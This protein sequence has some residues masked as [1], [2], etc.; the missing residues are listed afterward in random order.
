M[1]TMAPNSSDPQKAELVLAQL[2]TLPPLAP[3]AARILALTDDSKSNAKQIVELVGADPALAARML[4]ILG[5]AEH[6]LRSQSISIENAVKMLGFSA[7]RQ[8]TL[9]LKVMETFGPSRD[10]DSAGGGF[11]RS[12][13][14]K[15]CLAVACAARGIASK[16][17]RFGSPDEA[18]VHGLLHDIGK[19]A[20]ETAM[21]KTFDRI[22]Q[23]ADRQRADIADIEREMIGVDHAVVGHRLAER[24]NLPA[25]L[26]ECIWLHHQ[27]PEGL[28]ASIAA[29]GHVQIVQLADAM[30]RE[31]RIGYSGNHRNVVGSRTL[32][33]RIGLSEAARQEIAASL[34]EEIEKRAAW[35]GAEALNSRE[36]Y[37][38]ALMQTTEE[39]TSANAEL[40]DRSL[41]LQREREYFSALQRL[42]R[43]ITPRA[44]V[45]EVCGIAASV[46]QD[47]L[48]THQIHV[49]V[50]TADGRW[51]EWGS[52]DAIVRTGIEECPA[53]AR[54]DSIDTVA[55]V[56]MTR[57]AFGWA[58]PV[59]S[60]AKWAERLRGMLGSGPLWLFPIVRE[61]HWVGGAILAESPARV[62][63]LRSE[64]GELEALSA[65]MGL[66]IEQVQARAAAV[67][68]SDELAE[69]NRKLG[70]VESELLAARNLETVVS[71]AAGAA[72]ELN[73]PL[74]VIA[75]RAQMLIRREDRPDV[76]EGLEII[77]RQ[78]H[79]CSA[80]VTELMEFA[81]TPEPRPDAVELRACIDR[82][83]SELTGSGLL[84][85][86]QLSNEVASDSAK[87]LFDPAH[88]E[89][90]FREIL[91]NAIDA[92][93]AAS[94]RL[95]V[96][97]ATQ[98]TEDGV[99]IHVID[100]GLGM[101]ANVLDRAMEPFFSERPAGRG[102][103]LGLARVRRW[104]HEG[105]GRIQL[106]SQPG[107]GTI[108]ELRLPA[109]GG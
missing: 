37:L 94:R 44:G 5:R 14:W 60:L 26:S 82:V 49:N 93:D 83:A 34:V 22:V 66:A 69:V 57:G 104:L 50:A 63:A 12:E 89:G 8:I 105:G 10:A 52:A 15:H 101:S 92:T 102:R 99:V 106:D 40:S 19:I 16:L 90:V 61:Q 62:A 64:T 98:S 18:F 42:N 96:K 77:A 4:S 97:Q 95:C 3:I 85:E 27:H 59:G 72:H 76:R 43:E 25:K 30:A 70:A 23:I 13:F 38:R 33:A 73:N 81:R 29:G 91:R 1:T 48:R 51:V 17:V 56:E 36:V 100:N 65:A 7:I 78:A 45:R 24:W 86:D 67:S 11:D 88:L 28:P 20:L 107:K 39:L 87:V 58:P 79:G 75:G 55:A 35:I 21:P 71:L 9:A 31:Q 2:D 80:I 108:V 47:V 68:L 32:A 54:F 41:R 74:A 109:A 53:E 103:G 84:E 46:L 6:G